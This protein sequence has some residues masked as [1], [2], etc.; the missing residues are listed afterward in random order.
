MN[1]LYTIFPKTILRSQLDR[2][3][4]TEELEFVKEQEMFCIP[5]I[6]NIQTAK[7]YILNFPQMCDIKNIILEKLEF[8]FREVL[9]VDDNLNV[10][11]T[12]SWLNYS[13]TGGYHHLHSHPNSFLSGVLYIQAEAEKDKIVFK[14]QNSI[15]DNGFFKIF[16][17]VKEE[18]IYNAP[19]WFFPVK[20]GEIIIFPSTLEHHV[21]ET[22]SE[23]VR[24]S[25]AFNAFLK[26]KM[27]SVREATELFL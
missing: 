19:S 8:Y 20:T 16:E 9:C 5:N 15:V 26:G 25:L 11:L 3:F 6:A 10:Y 17:Q 4:T 21:P 22:E 13:Y 23:N 1:T 14:D 24:I 27:G 2:D 7:K 12:Q 18:N